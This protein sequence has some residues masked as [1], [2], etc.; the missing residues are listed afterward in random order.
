[1]ATLKVDDRGVLVDCASCG[2]TNRLAYA[3]LG[4]RVRCAR[5][6]QPIAAPSEPAEVASVDHFDLLV[7]QLSLP[8]VV[9][10]WAPW[11]GPCHMVAPELA[12]V[13]RRN[14]GRFLVVK[15]NIDALST[16]AERFGVRSIPMLAVFS[17]GHE[18]AR[19][20]GA[21]PAAEI[22]SFVAHAAQSADERAG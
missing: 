14:A 22:E 4:G 12:M 11:C 1:M 18:V 3:R 19:I 7:S 15:V 21:R 2:Q 5:C 16:L 9:D 20:A 17:R 8:I 10:F 6:K 13:A